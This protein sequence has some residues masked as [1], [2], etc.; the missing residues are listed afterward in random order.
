[1]TQG[2][3]VFEAVSAV[4]GTREH[5][6]AVVLDPADLKEVHAMMF[7]MFKTGVTSHSKNPDDAT[8]LKYIPGL[9]NNWLRKDPRLNG[10]VKYEAKNPG[11]RSGSGDESVRAMKALLSVTTDSAARA[12]IEAA[13]ATRLEQIKPK[14]EIKVDALPPELRH[15]VK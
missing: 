6:M 12:Q 9:V 8:L 15:L 10:G 5:D 13:I 7:T 14:V 11:S 3:A 4:V 1:M 2:D